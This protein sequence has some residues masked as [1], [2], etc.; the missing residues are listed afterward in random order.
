MKNI[1]NYS[2]FVKHLNET[3]SPEDFIH[4]KDYPPK[5]TYKSLRD[6]ELR[7]EKANGTENSEDLPW[8]DVIKIGNKKYILSEYGS[9]RNDYMIFS[10]IDNPDDYFQVNY[11]S[12]THNRGELTSS[13]EF[14]SL[15]D[16]TE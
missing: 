1:K 11:Q 10:C 13:F 9:A 15:N 4:Y 8:G 12:I 6:F 5:F 2:D 3:I 7:L 16:D 14:Y